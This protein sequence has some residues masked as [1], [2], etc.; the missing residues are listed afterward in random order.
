[1]VP[2]AQAPTPWT[3]ICR[4][5][6]GNRSIRLSSAPMP[7]SVPF[8]ALSRARRCLGRNL[9]LHS[10]CSRCAAR[11]WWTTSVATT[12]PRHRPPC[13]T[14]TWPSKR[15]TRVSW[16]STPAPGTGR[17]PGDGWR[18]PRTRVATA[19]IRAGRRGWSP[20]TS[21]PPACP[22]R[23]AP[24]TASSSLRCRRHRACRL[25]TR[26]RTVHGATMVARST[27]RLRPPTPLPATTA[28]PTVEPPLTGLSGG[29]TRK[30][31][32]AAPRPRAPTTHRRRVRTE[33]TRRRAPPPTT[34]TR[35]G[36]TATT[37]RRRPRRR[38]PH[39]RDRARRRRA[40]IPFC[41]LLPPGGRGPFGRR[42]ARERP[43]RHSLLDG[44]C[45]P[46]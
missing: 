14:M 4:S 39:A 33:R 3:S 5:R 6:L 24:R 11:L 46:P 28:Q 23:T 32:L 27:R 17:P 25:R 38:F 35:P 15:C 16:S 1:M 19:R 41:G 30:R 2:G 29:R 26:P 22:L 37:P 13:A 18:S 31:T 44:D 8:R 45:E 21:R 34:P 7:T 40:G 12:T 9:R 20:R 36:P 43:C 10:R 42:A